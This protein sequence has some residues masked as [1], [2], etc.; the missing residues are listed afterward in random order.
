MAF[1]KVMASSIETIIPQVPYRVKPFFIISNIS[2]VSAIDDSA[3]VVLRF[4]RLRQRSF[5]FIGRRMDSDLLNKVAICLVEPIKAGNIGS[6]AR[7]MKN[8]GLSR[9]ILINPPDLEDPECKKMSAGAY[10]IVKS[11]EI[12]S[13]LREAVAPFQMAVSTTRRLGK[14]R[15]PDFTPR[16]FAEHLRTQL[17]ET[18]AVICFGREDSGLTTEEID[19]APLILTIPSHRKYASLNL[20]QAVMLVCYELFTASIEENHGVSREL[21]D[22]D[23]IERYFEQVQPLLLECGFLDPNNPSWIMRTL[24]KII[25]RAQLEHREI[26]ILRGICSD[27]E[28]YL[29]H[30][31]KEG[32][33]DG[34]RNVDGRSGT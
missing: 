9:L 19:L 29:N 22:S 4:I 33:R 10:D 1:F 17:H 34:I 3:R 12:K 24:R 11:S 23:Q 7:A 5:F 32:K 30:V 28:W 2:N 21:C 20:A 16:S 8:M 14:G 25:H 18:S 13:N 31:A 6:V 27:L 26:K 15:A